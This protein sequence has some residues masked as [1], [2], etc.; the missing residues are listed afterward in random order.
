MK[1]V[2]VS[3]LIAFI[4]IAGATSYSIYQKHKMK[5]IEEHV[6]DVIKVPQ[7]NV[8]V[9]TPTETETSGD[10]SNPLNLENDTL[11]DKECCPEDETSELYD[12]HTSQDTFTA[13]AHIHT[14]TKGSEEKLTG[15]AWV[16]KHLTEKHGHS[17]D[18][19]RYIYY[20]N[21][22]LSDKMK[23]FEEVLE[24]TRLQYKYHPSEEIKELLEHFEDIA[25]HLELMADF[26]M[27]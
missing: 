8:A 17:P 5:A 15:D 26:W 4:L 19:D 25:K 14:E 23:T 1:K 20:N 12:F 21:L 18:I 9:A 7:P 2:W 22:M 10:T 16:R 3:I 24:F 6:A 11:S 27:Q 13:E